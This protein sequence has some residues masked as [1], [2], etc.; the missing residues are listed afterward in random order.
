MPTHVSPRLRARF[1]LPEIAAQ[2]L[3]NGATIIECLPHQSFTS[4][5]VLG[6]SLKKLHFTSYYHTISHH[7][8]VGYIPFNSWLWQSYPHWS[9][10]QAAAWSPN[11]SFISKALPLPGDRLVFFGPVGGG[12]EKSLLG[13]F[14]RNLNKQFFWFKK[15]TSIS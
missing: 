11:M 2:L 10:D 15:A 8:L 13:A 5:I 9:G 3:R 12:G 6:C 1:F 7:F 14:F 4:M